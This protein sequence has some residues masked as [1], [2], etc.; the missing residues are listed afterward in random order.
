MS[1][2]DR[3]RIGEFEPLV[4]VVDEVADMVDIA[5][6]LEVPVSLRRPYMNNDRFLPR[7]PSEFLVRGC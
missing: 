1:F 4:P 5:D 3:R 7:S 6:S 2:T